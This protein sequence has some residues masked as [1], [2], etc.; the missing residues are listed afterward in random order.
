MTDIY[1]EPQINASPDDPWQNLA[2]AYL[3]DLADIDERRITDLF[4]AEGHRWDSSKPLQAER[5]PTSPIPP[6]LP[7][8]R[9][10]HRPHRADSSNGENDDAR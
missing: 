9:T 1:T 3:A 10:Q 6:P 2:A 7:P 5:P 8:R 4:I